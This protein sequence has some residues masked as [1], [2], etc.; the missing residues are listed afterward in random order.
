MNEG[1]CERG[2]LRRR[3]RRRSCRRLLLL[4]LHTPQVVSD[5]DAQVVLIEVCLLKLERRLDC[6]LLLL[7]LQVGELGALDRRQP[8]KVG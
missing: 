4:D 8:L 2:S 6:G 7:R 1:R 5:E 3:R